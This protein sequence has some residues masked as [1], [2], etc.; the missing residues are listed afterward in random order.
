MPEVRAHVDAADRSP[1]GVPEV[2]QQE[3]GREVRDTYYVEENEAFD[4][5]GSR[6]K[7]DLDNDR[8][9]PRYLGCAF[10]E[11]PASKQC[12]NHCEFHEELF[13]EYEKGYLNGNA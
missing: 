3:M 12:S 8:F 2:Q 13:R 5:R 9:G 11:K 7:N 10:C 1:E 6:V 4:A